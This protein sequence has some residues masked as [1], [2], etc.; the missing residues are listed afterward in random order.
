M[1]GKKPRILVI[2][3]SVLELRA[4]CKILSP[5]YDVQA[6]KSGREGLEIAMSTDIDLVLLDLNMPGMSGFEVL[7]ELK[8]T[9]KTA[10]IPVIIVTSSESSNDEVRGLA[11][12][13]SDFIRKPLDAIV[14]FRVGMC[15][16][17]ISQMRMIEKFG[18]VDGLTGI[19]NRRSFDQTVRSEW[20][21]ALRNGEHLGLM[22]ID[23]DRFKQF[24]DEYGHI[25]GDVCLKEVA[26]I[27]VA[28]VFRGCDSVF[29]W[30]GEEFAIILPATPLAGA[31]EVAERVRAN[32]ESARISLGD[33]VASVTVS[34][35][36]GSMVPTVPF[37]ASG[38]YDNFRNEIDKALYRA[39]REG[40]N[41]VAAYCPATE[42]GG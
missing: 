26:E 7:C 4:T 42:T 29:R 17:L 11:L 8:D 15:L 21:H 25:N 6:A 24:N 40:R 32:I 36:V 10:H 37:E 18:L 2:D 5:M 9:E 3:D 33:E 19:N 22:M 20:I 12:G 34:I 28:T 31:V 41:R 39:K 30:G 23:I 38:E 16:Q 27:M 14:S 1:F 13:A 35:G